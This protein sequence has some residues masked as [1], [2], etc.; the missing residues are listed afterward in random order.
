MGDEIDIKTERL[1]Q[2]LE[3]ENLGGVLLN[4]QHN[5]A[6][7]TGG[8]SNG[9]D[10]SRENGAASIFVRR[11]GKRFLLAN[12]IE[13]PRLLAEGVSDDFEPVEFTWQEEKAVGDLAIR[14]AKALTVGGVDTDLFFDRGIQ[15]IESKIAPCRFELTNSEIERFRMLGNEAAAAMSRTIDAIEPGTTEMEI[16]A[17]LR[18]ELSAKN[19]ASVVTLIAADERIATY[20]HPVPT[21]KRWTKTLLIVTCAKRSGLIASLSRVVCVGS[22]PNELKEKTEAA[23]FVNASLWDATHAEASGSEL[24]QVAANAYKKVGFA[25]EINNHHQG[26]ATGYKTRDWVA[27]PKSEERVKP[28]QAFA[29]NPT[30]AG[31]KVEET[32]IAASTGIDVIT[33]LDG[34]PNIEH[35]LNGTIYSSPGIIER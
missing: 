20:R 25:D 8:G 17:K 27:H 29:W 1:V 4:A 19:I 16:A 23:A 22:V 24:Y 35:E 31:T 3:T 6:W 5:F 7:V 34:Q 13:M 2:M 10:L 32:V 28:N 26:G 14:K 18:G 21:R 11:D 9:I 12:N 30:I 33:A 15:T